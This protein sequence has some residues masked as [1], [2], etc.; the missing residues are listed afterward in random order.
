MAA[1]RSVHFVRPRMT[2]HSVLAIVPVLFACSH[3]ESPPPRAGYVHQEQGE[4]VSP[5]PTPEPVLVL[6]PGTPAMDQ[7]PH[8]KLKIGHFRNDQYNIG[9]TIDLLTDATDS[10]ADVDPAKL[11][12][13]G[14]EKV[15]KLEGRRGG[16]GRVDYVRAGD[17]VML[18][19]TRGGH[20]T[21]YVPDPESGRSGDAIELY[22]DADA[23][24]L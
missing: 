11:R 20:A 23:D 21:I 6:V 13:D 5:A 3:G 8:V 24:P 15:W 19:I 1:A 10:V 14:D 2:N 22:R 16:N 12:F 9:V 4:V 18:Q 7:P 17:R